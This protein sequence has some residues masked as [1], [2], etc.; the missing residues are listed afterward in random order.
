[1]VEPADLDIDGPVAPPQLNAGRLWAGGV[2]TAVVAALVVIAG[3]YIAR[4]CR[5][6]SSPRWSIWS[7]AWP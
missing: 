2:A 1:M 6:R 4:T 5:A 7:R 3:V